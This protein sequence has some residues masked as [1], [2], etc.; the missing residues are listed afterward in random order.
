MT[1]LFC[2][3]LWTRPSCTGVLSPPAVLCCDWVSFLFRSWIIVKRG[4]KL[5]AVKSLLSYKTL[6]LLHF[7]LALNYSCVQRPWVCFFFCFFCHNLFA[8][9]HRSLAN[10]FSSLQLSKQAQSQHNDNVVSFQPCRALLSHF[11][12]S[13][14]YFRVL[15]NHW[16]FFCRYLVTHLMGAD[17]NNIIKCQKLTDDHVQFLI[18]QILRGLKVGGAL[19]MHKST[20]APSTSYQPES[21][22]VNNWRKVHWTMLTS[23]FFCPTVHPFCRHHPQSKFLFLPVSHNKAVFGSWFRSDFRL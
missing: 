8:C 13:R 6:P 4:N 12:V 22:I 11:M 9:L 21:N 10:A 2:L 5:P 23:L 14:F 16:L 20:E 15:E 1:P 17:L 18:Y 3:V 7:T 19:K